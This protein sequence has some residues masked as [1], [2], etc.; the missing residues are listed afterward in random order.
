MFL[1]F[2]GVDLSLSPS[3]PLPPVKTQGNETHRCRL[4][5]LRVQP[6]LERVQEEL[7]RPPDGRPVAP[8]DQDAHR[9]QRVDAPVRVLLVDAVEELEQPAAHVGRDLPH[10][11]EVV[12]DQPPA[13]GARVGGD[14]AR[15]GVGVEEAVR[16]QLLQV[17]L[18]GAAREQRAID[19]RRVELGR[20]VDLDARRV[21]HRQ[22]LG[23]RALPEHARDLDPL[24]AGEALAEPVRAPPLERVVDLLVEDARALV[25]DRDPVPR[26]AVRLGV[27]RLQPARE[28]AHVLEVDVEELLEP[29]ALDLDHDAL[30]P[31]A[32]EVHLAQAG[33]G[34][35]LRVK[36][37]EQLRDGRAQVALDRRDGELRVEG[38][39]VVLQLLELC[40]EL[41]GQDVDP[42]RK[43]LPDLDE[44]GPELDQPLAQPGRQGRPPRGD[45]LGGHA[46][47]FL[48]VGPRAA[49][50][51]E[52][53]EED[54][55][56]R[57][58]LERALQRAVLAE[59]A[60]PSSGSRVRR[61]GLL[62]RRGGVRAA[63][64]AAAAGLVGRGA[65]A[66]APAGPRLSLL[67]R[68]AREQRGLLRV[69]L[70]ETLLRARLELPDLARVHDA[71]GVDLDDGGGDR[72]EGR[73]GGRAV[74]G[75]AVGGDAVDCC[76]V[77]SCSVDS[78]P[79]FGSAAVQGDPVGFHDRRGRGLPAG[80]GL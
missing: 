61:V 78:H 42:G 7:R 63:A 64:A 15:V 33:R 35:R 2:V 9:E 10:H 6:L 53:E 41:G 24:R 48:G 25:V 13:A 68:L 56:E 70:G 72:G 4:G 80:D 21:L 40:H 32:R 44:R 45:V 60:P 65:P 69:P 5:P 22:H 47:S 27:G 36:L 49:D 75:D 14:V 28:Q 38:R 58:D 77:D 31:E 18:H 19:A 16:Q 79:V 30:A 20:A 67:R 11:A 76:S 54:D 43:L 50:E 57:P 12:V 46:P 17:A 73:G 39:H 66:A 74:E 51:P 8:G 34:D 62:G 37:L 71:G 26:G 3:R 23:R 29:R 55:G 1:L 59:A 52:L